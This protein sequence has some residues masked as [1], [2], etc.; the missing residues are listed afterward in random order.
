MNYDSEILNQFLDYKK[1]KIF[2]KIKKVL[3]RRQTESDK[4]NYQIKSP[5]DKIECILCGGNYIRTLKCVHDKTKKHKRE[6]DKIYEAVKEKDIKIY[7]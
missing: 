3:R 1:A 7:Y 2:E 4:K 6:L 5:N